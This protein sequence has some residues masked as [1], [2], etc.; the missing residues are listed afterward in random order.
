VKWTGALF[1]FRFGKVFF[2]FATCE[3]FFGGLGKQDEPTRCLD[4]VVYGS[5]VLNCMALWAG[6]YSD[7]VHRIA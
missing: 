6:P 2:C 1:L 5:I 7:Y 4:P 3:I